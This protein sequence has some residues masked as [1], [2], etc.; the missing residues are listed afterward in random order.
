[1]TGPSDSIGTASP[2]RSTSDGA[3]APAR[4]ELRNRKVRREMV[5][6]QVRRNNALNNSMQK[7]LTQ[8]RSISSHKDVP[9]YLARAEAELASA[10]TQLKPNESGNGPNNAAKNFSKALENYN[11]QASNFI[12]QAIK[13]GRADVDPSFRASMAN[14]VSGLVSNLAFSVPA[15]AAT[16]TRLALMANG[17]SSDD[18]NHKS[19]IVFAVGAGLMVGAT[20]I[21]ATETRHKLG[22]TNPTI[23]MNPGNHATTG[24]YQKMA[25]EIVDLLGGTVVYSAF[26]AM[27]VAANGS[28]TPDSAQNIVAEA[29]KSFFIAV[30][31]AVTMGLAKEIVYSAVAADTIRRSG[32]ETAAQQPLLAHNREAPRGVR[33]NQVKNPMSNREGFLA[34]TKVMGH[35]INIGSGVIAMAPLFLVNNA[36]RN[37]DT[38]FGAQFGKVVASFFAFFVTKVLAKAMATAQGQHPAKHAAKFA[39]TS[40]RTLE[41][42]LRASSMTEFRAALNGLGQDLAHSSQAGTQMGRDY[43]LARQALAAAPL[44]SAN[45]DNTFESMA[46]RLDQLAAEIVPAGQENLNS[47]LDDM[48]NHL[49]K[50]ALSFRMADDFVRSQPNSDRPI[51]DDDI[52]PP[53]VGQVYLDDAQRRLFDAQAV[54]VSIESSVGDHADD[55]RQIA[56][57]LPMLAALQKDDE[58][59]Q[60][61][62]LVK[63]LVDLKSA[64]GRI[65]QGVL[66]KLS[67]TDPL[68]ETICSRLTGN[69]RSLVSAE[70]F[71][72]SVIGGDQPPRAVIDALQ[73]AQ[74]KGGKAFHKDPALTLKLLIIENILN[75]EL[76]TGALRAAKKFTSTAEQRNE[77]AGDLNDLVDAMRSGGDVVGIS[78]ALKTKFQEGGLRADV[79]AMAV[80]TVLAEL[81]AAAGDPTPDALREFIGADFLEVLSR[82]FPGPVSQEKISTDV[83]KVFE[84]VGRSL[85]HMDGDQKAVFAAASKLNQ[86]FDRAQID[87]IEQKDS[88]YHPTNYNGVINSLAV[89]GNYMEDQSITHTN[90]A[91]IP[92]QLAHKTESTQYYSSIVSNGPA[93]RL[94]KVMMAG[95]D[96]ADMGLRYRSHDEA[97]AADFKA[98]IGTASDVQHK[99]G[100][101][102]TGFDVTDGPFIGEAIDAKMLANKGVFKSVGEVTLIKEIVSGIQQE[103]PRID[104]FASKAMLHCCSDRGL[105]L[106]LH[107][108]RGE[109]G[110]KNKYTELVTTL[111]KE[112]VAE[113]HGVDRMHTPDPLL[114]GTGVEN[115][116][117]VPPRMAKVSWAH[118]AGVS[119][120]TAE[121]PDHTQ[122][123]ATVLSD[124]SLKGHLYVDLSWD[125]IAH[126][127]TQ[128]TSDLLLRNID[129]D[130]IA[131]GMRRIASAL[132]SLV[133]SY[134][135]FASVGGQSDKAQD[136]GDL[137]LSAVHRRTGSKIAQMHLNQIGQFKAIVTDA[138][139]ENPAVG[140]KLLTMITSHG[141]HGNNWLNLLSEHSDRIMFGTDALA[142]GTKAHG[143][144]A[145]A[146]NTKIL[147]PVYNI[148]QAVADAI[149]NR[150]IGQP[151]IDELESATRP[152]AESLRKVVFDI[153]EGT[154]ADFFENEEMEA[155]RDAYEDSLEIG[156]NAFTATMNG[157]RLAPGGDAL[158]RAVEAEQ[159]TRAPTGSA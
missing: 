131:P 90:A 56:P 18:A 128:N 151:T 63:E 24:P 100:L 64:T 133:K 28:Q 50:A 146:V 145:Y 44:H 23:L 65:N 126:D 140:T 113:V 48:A 59:T 99:V 92:S 101:S 73:T 74:A 75:N 2:Q 158:G 4:K 91:G 34:N 1:M 20:S 26:R 33:L 30:S 150:T 32:V 60:A 12:S 15:G 7:M 6:A 109:P 148:F 62:T 51:T 84:G 40:A 54:I 85:A 16:A 39:L 124:E 31:S 118:A 122:N 104:S 17:A 154:Y 21:K 55:Q 153:A 22:G 78:N 42:E 11:T 143:E 53:S 72:L 138:I 35:A 97:L 68:A 106:V 29:T 87:P 67:S 144:A 93:A 130:A 69:G 102:I 82:E 79:V 52:N 14:L 83:T 129:D 77:A 41:K 86:V 57:L 152:T 27:L 123:L 137:A 61:T 45:P 142:V 8:M 70:A 43:A 149:E 156:G 10:V 155:R 107:C 95:A 49:T 13:N 80:H 117:G 58:A 112:W 114:A 159:A 19:E 135:S 25:G 139:R 47:D 76:I 108:D 94:M 71:A 103:T 38:S 115:P 110:N 147:Y 132:D 66:S 141:D 9:P 105:P 111:I 121:A 125:F 96:A 116:A 136:L 3:N 98:N 119:R 5:E 157:D 88:H 46:D 36:L 120:F 134:Q 127:I 81:E 89:L 37:S